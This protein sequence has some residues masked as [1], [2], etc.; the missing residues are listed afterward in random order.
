MINIVKSK[1]LRRKIRI[2]LFNRFALHDLWHIVFAVLKDLTLAERRTE[3]L[4][5]MLAQQTVQ[6]WFFNASTA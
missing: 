6:I 3:T 2:K 5:Q 1:V 4:G